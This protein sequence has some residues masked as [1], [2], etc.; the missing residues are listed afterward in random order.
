MC[1]ILHKC[2]A[3][4][5]VEIFVTNSLTHLLKPKLNLSPTVKKVRLPLR[6]AQSESALKVPEAE[7]N[8]IQAK[9]EVTNLISKLVESNLDEKSQSK[10]K[11]ETI[12]ENSEHDVR[13]ND[14]VTS[15]SAKCNGTVNNVV[16][17]LKLDDVTEESG[18]KS[19]AQL[20]EEEKTVTSQ[21][22][23]QDSISTGNDRASNRPVVPKFGYTQS[24]DG[25]A[26][27]LIHHSVPF[28]AAGS[29]NLDHMEIETITDI[30]TFLRNAKMVSAGA[31]LTPV[32]VSHK[33]PVG[34]KYG[35]VKR[36]L[37]ASNVSFAPDVEPNFYNGIPRNSIFH[38]S[39]GAKSRQ[40]L[41]QVKSLIPAISSTATTS[42]LSSLKPHERSTLMTSQA[43]NQSNHVFHSGAP[44]D[45][46]SS[47]VIISDDV[48]SLEGTQKRSA[49]TSAIAR[50]YGLLKAGTPSE[51]KPSHRLLRTPSGKTSHSLPA[52]LNRAEQTSVV[53]LSCNDNGN[54]IIS[55][56]RG[57]YFPIG[58]LLPA[59]DSSMRNS[60]P[61]RTRKTGETV[62]SRVN[63]G[64]SRDTSS[65][66]EEGT[67][68]KKQSIEVLRLNEREATVRTR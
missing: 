18:D 27:K 55:S 63:N 56:A 37:Q 57:P 38:G 36:T 42:G 62:E 5:D 59:A 28:F 64:A 50:K 60:M 53:E 10:T 35:I 25:P 40:R 65:K 44:P 49:L 23:S 66:V 8:R 21:V 22:S 46:S 19:S 43:T 39:A 9:A 3:I 47:S 51:L 61:V 7:L 16:P 45:L 31:H 29:R 13:T 41:E 2:R 58:D 26:Q 15:D 24:T 67:P 20:R 68:V 12:A 33:P 54:Y 14:D 34:R 32:A 30:N 1:T 4:D 48:T 52:S 11:I 6:H 17:A